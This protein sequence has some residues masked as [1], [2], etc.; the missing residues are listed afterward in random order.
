[1]V[2]IYFLNHKHLYESLK[3][4][5]KLAITTNAYYMLSTRKKITVNDMI[6]NC[7]LRMN[8][9]LHFNSGKNQNHFLFGDVKRSVHDSG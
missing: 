1:M 9:D 2:S 4:V 3:F 5:L 7:V 6:N 8:H